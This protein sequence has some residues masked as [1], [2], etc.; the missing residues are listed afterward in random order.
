LGGVWLPLFRGCGFQ[1]AAKAESQVLPRAAEKAALTNF[2]DTLPIVSQM[3]WR[4]PGHLPV[5]AVVRRTAAIS[6]LLRQWP[7]GNIPK[8]KIAEAMSTTRV[9]FAGRAILFANERKLLP[10]AFLYGIASVRVHSLWRSSFLH[11]EYSGVGFRTYFLWTF[12]LKTTIPALLA[13]T[14]GL[15][16]AVRRKTQWHSRMAFVVVPAGVY[17][18]V[19]ISC[20]QPCSRMGE[21]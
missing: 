12:L 6:E 2:R 18:V 20:R 15:A 13:I 1:Q 7:N 4:E 14:A 17:W 21:D 16:L 11:G 9:G 3:P 8:V 5:E 19:S 10:E